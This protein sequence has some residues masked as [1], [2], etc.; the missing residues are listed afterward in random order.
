MSVVEPC[1]DRPMALVPLSNDLLGRIEN[2]FFTKLYIVEFQ[3]NI[4]LSL[5]SLFYSTYVVYG[6]CY[7]FIRRI[8]ILEKFSIYSFVLIYLME[9]MWDS[10]PTSMCS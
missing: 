10:W 4:A 8:C 5:T 7:I 9:L 3:S 2:R 6:A 1:L